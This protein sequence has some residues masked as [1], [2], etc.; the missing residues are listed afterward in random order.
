MDS[1]PE[2]VADTRVNYYGSALDSNE[3]DEE[4]DLS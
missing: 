4:E 1:F 2:G 3:D